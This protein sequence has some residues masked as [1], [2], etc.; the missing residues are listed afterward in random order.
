MKQIKKHI[1]EHDFDE[2]LCLKYNICMIKTPYTDILEITTT[3]SHKQF[4]YVN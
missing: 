3:F 1:Y 4:R 2:N